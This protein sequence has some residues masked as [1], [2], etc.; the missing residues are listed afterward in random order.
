MKKMKKEDV[1]AVQSCLDLAHHAVGHSFEAASI[2]QYIRAENEIDVA[3]ANLTQAKE[4]LS[5][6][7]C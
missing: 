3:I 2:A 6:D 5:N 7:G 1:V 4:I